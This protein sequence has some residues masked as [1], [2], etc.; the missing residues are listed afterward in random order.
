M[1]TV[2]TRS[3]RAEVMS[4]SVGRHVRDT[5]VPESVVVEVSQARWL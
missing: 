2:S 1:R 5:T 3:V 4:P